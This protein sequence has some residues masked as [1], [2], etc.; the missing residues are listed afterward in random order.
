MPADAL[1]R[2]L[3]QA[4]DR[5]ATLRSVIHAVEY[6]AA[7]RDQHARE[8][9]GSLSWR[10]TAP[11]RHVERWFG[12][13]PGGLA[14]TAPLPWLV[15][16]QDVA[17]AERS[18]AAR[19]LLVRMATG[20]RCGADAPFDADRVARACTRPDATL[21][22]ARVVG[23]QPLQEGDEAFAAA[24]YRHHRERWGGAGWD[25]RD[26]VLHVDLLDRLGDRRAAAA[27]L[28]RSGLAR[29]S[30]QDE[31][32]LRANLARADGAGDAPDAW[33]AAI[34]RLFA[35]EGLEPVSL[36]AGT[37]DALDRLACEAAPVRGPQPLV[38][39]LMPVFQPDAAVDAAIASVLGQT[40]RNLELIIVDDGS[41]EDACR[42][43]LAWPERDPRVR[44][45]RAQGNAGTYA[46]RNLGLASA[47]G[48][49]VTC[50]DADD[51]SHPRK[52]ELQARHLLARAGRVGNL[53]RWARV[54]ADLRFERFSMG[55]GLVY[56]NISSL[57]FRR[58]PVLDRMGAWDRVRYGADSEFYKRIELVFGQRLAVVG[59]APLSFGRVHGGS[60]THGT[61]GR[62][63]VSFERRCYEAAWMHWHR[64]VAEGV[65][66][67]RLDPAGTARPFPA[68][69]AMLPDRGDAP[70]TFDVVLVADYTLGG[71]AARMFVQRAQ[72]CLD[73]GERVALCQ[74]RSLH[75]S[76]AGR[77]HLDAAAQRLV[78]AGAIAL[79]QPTDPVRAGRVEVLYPRVLEFTGHLEGA[80]EADRL[81]FAWPQETPALGAADRPLDPGACLREGRRLFRTRTSDEKRV[82][83]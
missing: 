48:E 65:A 27:A 20:G 46:V 6:E 24:L 9:L 52:I 1:A 76:V 2:D 32:C 34:G 42:R 25:V 29:S 77:Y 56:P 35:G 28:E 75:A 36:P 12:R 67:P 3:G 22:L 4:R 33:L 47:R 58:I 50:H 31:R 81:L 10:V 74:V 83:P 61:L 55:G 40:W 57:M 23:N 11:W 64:R 66:S 21:A 53:S 7:A 43:L 63:Y 78:N 68:P 54:T 30:P 72:A 19:D 71:A 15:A 26:H 49:L 14:P 18:P 41:P 17:L 60:L 45:L 79:V 70:R 51:W 8:L 5:L 59:A 39:V 38:S 73:R 37:G 82:F 69:A 62:G 80:I 13:R 16:L 44:L